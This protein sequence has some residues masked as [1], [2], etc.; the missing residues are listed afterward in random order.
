MPKRIDYEQM[1]L[2]I[3]EGWSNREIADRLGCNHR[4]VSKQRVA[5]GLANRREYC[6]RAVVDTPPL[7]TEGEIVRHWR[8]LADKAGGITVL[9]EL[10]LCRKDVIIDILRRHG[11]EP[12]KRR[13]RWDKR[14][15]ITT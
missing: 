6:R 9:A 7:M 8:S 3:R 12:K 14:E 13:T 1:R 2:L 11:Y 4:T 15:E 5:M 10:N